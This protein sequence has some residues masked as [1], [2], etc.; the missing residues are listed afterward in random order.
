MLVLSYSAGMAPRLFL[1]PSTVIGHYTAKQVLNLPSAT[2][3]IDRTPPPHGPAML[4]LD[5]CF[6]AVTDVLQS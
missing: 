1:H 2:L 6:I 3:H 4:R 5:H